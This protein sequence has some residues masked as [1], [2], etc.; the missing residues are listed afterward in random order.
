M[1]MFASGYCTFFECFSHTLIAVNRYTVISDP[2]A[3]LNVWSG[4]PFL[5]VIAGQF[6]VPFLFSAVRL[7]D[8]PKLIDAG[9][10]YAIKLYGVPY[11]TAVLSV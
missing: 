8:N 2:T 4:K 11:R 3:E 5:V 7:M 9:D 10:G 1:F 6:I